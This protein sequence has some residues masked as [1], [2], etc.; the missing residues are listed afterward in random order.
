LNLNFNLDLEQLRGYR[1]DGEME[2]LLLALALFKV[3]TFLSSGLRPSHGLR[4][5]GIFAGCENANRLCASGAERAGN[6]LPLLIDAARDHL[7]SADLSRSAMA[8]MLVL[9]C[10]Q[11]STR[12]VALRVRSWAWDTT[13]AEIVRRVVQAFQPGRVYPWVAKARDATADVRPRREAR[14]HTS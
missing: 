3:Q 13:L 11:R 2:Q 12:M 7:A 8:P 6:E 9:V 10:S 4:S 1:L 14:R 5:L